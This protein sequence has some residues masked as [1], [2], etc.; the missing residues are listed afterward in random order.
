MD[1]VPGWNFTLESSGTVLLKA[2]ISSRPP[3]LISSGTNQVEYLFFCAFGKS[4]VNR[5]RIQ[6][7]GLRI[8]REGLYDLATICHC[9]YQPG[10]WGRRK[11]ARSSVSSE[12]YFITEPGVVGANPIELL[13]R[14]FRCQF[15]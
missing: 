9:G 15:R 1:I 2:R 4:D 12:G 6:P 5:N 3:M 8:A 14:I 13:L 11:D 7:Q 10:F